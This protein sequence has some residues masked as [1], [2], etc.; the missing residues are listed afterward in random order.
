MPLGV[1]NDEDRKRLTKAWPHRPATE[2]KFGL[3]EWINFKAG[4]AMSCGEAVEVVV[5]KVEKV[6]RAQHTQGKMNGLE[7]K[8]AQHLEERKLCREIVDYRFEPMKL[9][10]APSTFLDM[11][12][13]VVLADTRF[14]ALPL[15]VELH[16]TKGHWE[17]DARVKIKVAAT[18][19][20]WWRFVGVQWNKAMKDWKFEEF[21]P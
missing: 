17:D 14:E 1:V 5:Q 7:K 6:G 15:V 4:M 19:F 21:K 8:Y 12:F 18:M 3:D 9:R 2:M 16:E 11:D 13:L 10:L 20:P